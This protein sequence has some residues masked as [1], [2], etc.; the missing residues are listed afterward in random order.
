MRH[1]KLWYALC[2]VNIIISGMF[3][4]FYFIDRVNPAMDFMGSTLSK[5][6]LFLFCLC[7]LASS[8]LNAR[9]LFLLMKRRA[10]A[11]IR[12][13]GEPEEHKTR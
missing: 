10:R 5:G 9:Y 6:L 1:L 3:I 12:K 11:A 2:H 7:I 8:I 4:L 13:S